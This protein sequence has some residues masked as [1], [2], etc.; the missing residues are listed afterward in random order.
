[1]LSRRHFLVT[2]LAL[3]APALG[4]LPGHA[5]AKLATLSKP[6]PPSTAMDSG[7]FVPA[8]A[9][10]LRLIERFPALHPGKATLCSVASTTRREAEL[11]HVQRLVNTG[12][13]FRPESR[14]LWQPAALSGD[15]EDFAISKLAR[16]TGEFG[17]PRG[18]LTLAT[19]RAES[20]QGH[21]VLLAHTA[22]GTYVLDNRRAAVLPWRSLPY[23]W[24]AREEPGSPF[25]LWRALAA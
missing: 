13:R 3:A 10:W 11:D 23:R 9:A 20:G 1:M 22:R 15:C 5:E 8:P 18:A 7:K 21:A 2:G 24:R 6:L 17:W 12:V 14:D 25:D 16:L 4:M 19:C